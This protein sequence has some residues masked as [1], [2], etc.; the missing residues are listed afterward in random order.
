MLLKTVERIG[1]ISYNKEIADGIYRMRIDAP[2]IAES[3]RPGQFAHIL[4]DVDTYLLRRPLSISRVTD[5][6]IEMLY[7]VKGIGTRIM[8]QMRE[9]KPIDVMGPLGKGFNI[10]EGRTAVVGGGI[11]LAPLAYLAEWLKGDTD[12]YLGFNDEPFALDSFDG[13]KVNVATMT[14][15]YGFKGDVTKLLLEKL[16]DNTYDRIYACGP[17]AMIK[18]LKEITDRFEIPAEASFEERMGC[19]LGACMVCGIRISEGADWTYKRVCKD[20]PVFELT[21]VII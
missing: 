9:G 16:M 2:W 15:R 11:G 14:G 10:I 3:A 13:L 18:S 20:G 21:K 12:I 8:T 19:G 7:K 1:R 6:E 5:G 17:K 4:I